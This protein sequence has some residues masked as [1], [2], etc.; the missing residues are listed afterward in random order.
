MEELNA[1]EVQWLRLPPPAAAQGM[2]QRQAFE[3]EPAK[4]LQ[5]VFK[6]NKGAGKAPALVVVYSS[7]ARGEV[8]GVLARHGY[9]RGP[10]H[11][12][13]WFQTDGSNECSIEVWHRDPV[14]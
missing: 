2:S 9:R 7:T 8:S 3:A 4:Y 1:A 5:S 12:N 14:R 10:V 6:L 13:C 11:A